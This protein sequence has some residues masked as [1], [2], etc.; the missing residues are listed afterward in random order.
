M[1]EFEQEMK[2]QG[3]WDNVTIIQTSEFARTVK[4]NGAGTDHAWGGHYFLAGGSVQGSKIHGRYPDRIDDNAPLSTR[5]GGRFIPTTS[6]EAVWH[7]IAEWFGVDASKMGD[8]LPQ[9][10]NFPPS[11]MMTKEAMFVNL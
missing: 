2:L 4:A 3:L 8:V 10:G 11:A 1:S 7:G 6:W 9:R 5:K